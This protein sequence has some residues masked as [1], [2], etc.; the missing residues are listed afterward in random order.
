MITKI[1]R[2]IFQT[3][4]TK[5]LS[6]EASLLTASW[7]TKNRSYAH[8]LFDEHDNRAFIK[9]HFGDRVYSAYCRLIPGTHRANLW[10]YCALYVFGGVYVDLDCVCVSDIDSFLEEDT[11]MMVPFDR[12]IY[13]Q[14]MLYSSF[15]AVVPNHPVMLDCVNRIVRIVETGKVPSL[16]YE[17]SGSGLLGM[18]VN[19]HLGRAERESF[20]IMVG[21][22]GG[23]IPGGPTKIKL[24]VFDP[25]T[26]CIV[27]PVTK[28]KL[29]VEKDASA[30]L[31]HMY[32][33][34][35]KQI[36]SI[37]YEWCKCPVSL[38]PIALP[39]PPPTS[40][41]PS[42]QT[43]TPSAPTLCNGVGSHQASLSYE[44]GGMALRK[45]PRRLFQTWE[46]T[47][48]TPTMQI[49]VDGWADRNPTYMH[50]LIDAAGRQTMI[51]RH[52]GQ[53][54]LDAYNRLI[55]GAYKADL[56]RLCALY[57]F[58]G[59]YADIDMLCLGSLDDII[60]ETT[61]FVAVVDIFNPRTPNAHTLAN[62]FIASVPKHPVLLDCIKRIVANVEREYNPGYIKWFDITGPGVLGKA[63]NVYLERAETTS[64]QGMQGTTITDDG[65][66][67]LL[68]FEPKTEV[69]KDSETKISIFQNKNGNPLIQMIYNL[70]RSRHGV[71][72]FGAHAQIY[73]PAVPLHPPTLLIQT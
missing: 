47:D 73:L 18:A 52:F 65:K 28:R 57:V 29:T 51:Q 5:P 38:D 8:Y 14:H 67:K 66:I 2:N 72:N 1:P 71:K 13:S 63:M 40:F 32:D 41:S 60:G 15:I 34:E 22:G 19:A 53:D 9:R 3:W 70:E 24:L 44:S 69:V 61:E 56:W 50:C 48:L 6:P 54:V 64:F 26:A 27:D 68:L 10:K 35:K 43:P 31:T 36:G 62:G 42:S 20:E 7:K 49:L 45:I 58:G 25:T 17:V 21:G 33:A 16:C 39:P 37:R 55:P 12:P 4:R 46:T 59:V 11:E 23:V 30:I